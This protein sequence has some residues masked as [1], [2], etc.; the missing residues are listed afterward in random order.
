MKKT[1]KSKAKKTAMTK[2]VSKAKPFTP[3]MKQIKGLAK[4]RRVQKK[5]MELMKE[6]GQRTVTKKVYNMTLRD[7]MKKAAK[8]V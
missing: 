3:S 5:A 8:M 2:N 6:S 7:A 4:G 1:Q